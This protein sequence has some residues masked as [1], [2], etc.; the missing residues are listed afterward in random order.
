MGRE[1]EL[2]ALFLRYCSFWCKERNQIVSTDLAEPHEPFIHVHVC[3][4]CGRASRREEFDDLAQTTGIYLCPECGVEG[5]LNIEIRAADALE[6]AS[7][8]AD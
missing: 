8:N 3:V 5:P 2:T 7:G 6:D 4:H 1:S